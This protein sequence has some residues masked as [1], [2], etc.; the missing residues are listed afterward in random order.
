MFEL[1]S[2]CMLAK[3][4]VIKKVDNGTNRKDYRSTGTEEW[5]IIED[6]EPV[7]DAGVCD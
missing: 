1:S 7:D 4:K 6:G 2:Y 5:D 3:L